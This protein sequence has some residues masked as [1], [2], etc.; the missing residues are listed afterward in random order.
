MQ[1]TRAIE[2]VQTLGHARQSVK[3]TSK[4]SVMVEHVKT[5]HYSQV[6]QTQRDL[7]HPAKCVAK[8]IPVSRLLSG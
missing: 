7:G 1:I 3:L 8:P 2:P 6:S 5:Q 4:L